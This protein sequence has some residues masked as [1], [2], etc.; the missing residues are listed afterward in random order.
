MSKKV[1]D[2]CILG[3]GAGGGTLAAHLAHRGVNVS[4]VEGGPTINTRTDFNTHA[5]K[6]LTA[7][8]Y[9]TSRIGLMQELGYNG[10]A[11]LAAFP[12]ST[13]PEH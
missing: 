10:D 13:I 12:Q 4:V 3:S 8:G 11:V 9:Y 6:N 2:I 1:V 5:L 7:D